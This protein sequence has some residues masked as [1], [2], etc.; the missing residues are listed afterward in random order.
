MKKTLLTLLTAFCVLSV[1]AVDPVNP[2]YTEPDGAFFTPYLF[3][4][5][6]N[7]GAHVPQMIMPAMSS[8][9]FTSA[10]AG[11]WTMGEQGAKG[12][13]SFSPEYAFGTYSGNVIPTFNDGTED[14]TYGA[15]ST[16]GSARQV[17][18]ASTTEKWMTN[19]KYYA[20]GTS[21]KCIVSK[22]SNYLKFRV[23]FYNNPNQVMR[24]SEL[25]IPI[26]T[27]GNG[28][29]KADLFPEGASMNVAIYNATCT[30]AADGKYTN[31]KGSTTL[32]APVTLTV[33]SFLPTTSSEYSGVLHYKLEKPIL[34]TG[35]F[36]IE[37]TDF[38]TMGAEAR[39]YADNCTGTTS[40]G[41]KYK[42]ADATSLSVYGLTNNLLVA[43]KGMFYSI[44][45]EEDVD[46]LEYEVE[47]GDQ[48]V[49]FYTNGV[50]KEDYITKPDWVNY[51]ITYESDKQYTDKRN[52]M[53]MI[54]DENKGGER[55]GEVVIN[56]NGMKL[57]YK[58]KQAGISGPI[59]VD[60]ITLNHDEYTLEKGYKV[61]LKATLTPD[62]ATN[63]N[64][65]WT[66]SDESIVTV[67]ADGTI[68]YKGDGTATITA[69]TEDG[70]FTA[71]CVVK[72]I[73]Y[74]DYED[75]APLG[76]AVGTWDLVAKGKQLTELPAQ[77]CYLN[78]DNNIRRVKVSNFNYSTKDVA[79][80]V[81]IDWNAET[82]VCTIKQMSTGYATGGKTIYMA[83]SADGTY[84]P[85]TATFTL[86][87][88][89]YTTEAT[90]Y[91][92]TET[93][94]LDNTT[95]IETIKANT[96]N[97]S[98]IYNLNG[99]RVNLNAPGIKVINGK[100]FVK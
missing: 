45:P 15:G 9:T 16:S 7:A 28:T 40:K 2:K 95:A 60:G 54:V 90:I 36:V 47:G 13:T 80:D 5:G 77:V 19:A 14:Y 52:F 98:V 39:L 79:K 100:K 6:A 35:A 70:G 67:D 56:N 10:T 4:N 48:T 61:T 8:Y 43:V 31:T 34:V 29:T 94:T 69:T 23:F 44:M 24:I 50:I 68:H 72:T 75:F 93:F 62:G 49:G 25:C 46:V 30:K 33:D 38:E 1:W 85:S 59:A 64:I 73:S 71:T 96:L 84:D 76:S 41:L 91:E 88:K 57:I 99:Q 21:N 66:S 12:T 42:T 63:Q 22:M 51:E 92:T 11:D 86:P 20:P 87:M 78:G 83:T 27:N 26:T 17:Y 3:P 97:G 58:I 81:I 82:N 37:I 65:T 18:V 32:L 53:K 55:E 74:T 89:Y